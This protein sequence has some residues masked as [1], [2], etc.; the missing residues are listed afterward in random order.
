MLKHRLPY[1][2]EYVTHGFPIEIIFSS[3]QT[4]DTSYHLRFCTVVNFDLARPLVLR[5]FTW[6]VS[7]SCSPGD[8]V[9]IKFGFSVLVAH[10]LEPV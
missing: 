2:E 9:P 6:N 7:N 1:Y 10:I 4:K 5:W 3:K 8:V